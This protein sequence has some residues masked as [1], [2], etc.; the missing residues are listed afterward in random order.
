VQFHEGPS[1][2]RLRPPACPPPDTPLAATA[3]SSGDGHAFTGG[4][5]SPAAPD[6]NPAPVPQT[7]VP[8][9][10]YPVG[11]PD[12][13]GAGWVPVNGVIA[14]PASGVVVSGPP[15]NTM[16]PFLTIPISAPA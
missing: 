10:S 6:R 12:A 7:W 13:G 1:E 15:D 9:P 3:D 4:P 5:N 16:L 14:L 2:E 11:I 8:S